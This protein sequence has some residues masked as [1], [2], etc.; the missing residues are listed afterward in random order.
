[1]RG[2]LIESRGHASSIL[3]ALSTSWDLLA[4]GTLIQSQINLL[5]LLFP[6][7]QPIAFIPY[8]KHSKPA[9]QYVTR[10][11]VIIMAIL[12]PETCPLYAHLIILFHK[13]GGFERLSSSLWSIPIMLRRISFGG[14][15]IASYESN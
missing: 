13:A 6:M 1:M 15:E 8:V 14:F 7:L 9:F 4:S 10:C 2:S 11:Y 12:S 3:A 5:P